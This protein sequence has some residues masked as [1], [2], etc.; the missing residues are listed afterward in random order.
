[1]SNGIERHHR[2]QFVR[3]LKTKSISVLRAHSFN[4][5]VAK[6]LN[7]NRRGMP[8]INLNLVHNLTTGHPSLARRRIHHRHDVSGNLHS[9]H[10]KHIFPL[11]SLLISVAP[12]V[13]SPGLLLFKAE[14]KIDK[15]VRSVPRDGLDLNGTV[16]KHAKTSIT[17]SI[18][19]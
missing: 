6:I 14:Q 19:I 11:I 13:F 10:V 7:V 15:V 1:M 18:S 16:A 17:A 3:R 4:C 5:S 8:C 2:S 12:S 9:F